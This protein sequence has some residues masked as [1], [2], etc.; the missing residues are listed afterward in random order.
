MLERGTCVGLE[1]NA[2]MKVTAPRWAT[3]GG[4]SEDTSVQA[5]PIGPPTSTGGSSVG[6]SA[7]EARRLSDA[8]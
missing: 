3:R 6:R 2:G 1:A 4:T 7:K 5:L 8:T